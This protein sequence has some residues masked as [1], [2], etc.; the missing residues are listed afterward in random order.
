M[1]LQSQWKVFLGTDAMDRRVVKRTLQEIVEVKARSLAFW[2]IQATFPV[3]SQD[4]LV[5]LKKKICFM[6]YHTLLFR[7]N[8]RF[9]LEL[10]KE[11]VTRANEIVDGF[12]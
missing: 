6:Q 3:S 5:N 10:L 12:A 4:G 7:L 8:Q 2:K 1:F 11:I 9:G